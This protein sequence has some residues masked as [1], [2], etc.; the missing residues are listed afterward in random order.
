MSKQSGTI[1]INNNKSNP[2]NKGNEVNTDNPSSNDN[3]SDKEKLQDLSKKSEDVL[4]KARTFSI[5]HP[6]WIIVDRE[7][8]TIVQKRWWIFQK[9]F[10]IRLDD[11]KTVVSNTAFIFGEIIFEIT[12]YERNPDVIRPFWPGETVK[13]KRIIL[14]LVIAKAEGID[15]TKLTKEDLINEIENIGKG[16]AE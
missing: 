13:I 9:R 3:R 6:S 1:E 8:V 7:K 4:Y 16:H 2:S 5:F 10:P 11:I 15:L 14:G 12:G